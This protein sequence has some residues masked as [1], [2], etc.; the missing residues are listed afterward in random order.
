MVDAVDSKSTELNPRAG[1]SPA[2]GIFFAHSRY[3][4]AS[5]NINRCILTCTLSRNR[6]Y[7]PKQTT[8]STSGFQACFFAFLVGI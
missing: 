5:C 1:S 8:C 3:E 4:G 2:F 6:H 7:E